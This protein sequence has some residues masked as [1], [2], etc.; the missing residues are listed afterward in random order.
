MLLRGFGMSVG[1]IN[2]SRNFILIGTAIIAAGKG[3]L[4]A[5]AVRRADALP[6]ADLPI[7]SLATLYVAGRYV[8][9]SITDCGCD[10]AL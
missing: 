4:L 9:M 6:G 10:Q 2:R 3:I 5:G 7:T 1:G 8:G